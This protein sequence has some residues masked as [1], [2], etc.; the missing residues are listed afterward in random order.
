MN[1]KAYTPVKEIK[2]CDEKQT[3]FDKNPQE[4]I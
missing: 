1:P 4:I 3:I 2:M